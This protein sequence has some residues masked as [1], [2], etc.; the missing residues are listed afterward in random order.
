MEITGTL[1][2]IGETITGTSKKNGNEWSKQQIV[3][4]TNDTYPQD[5]AIDFMGDKISQLTQY[6]V[7][8][9]VVVSINIKGNEYNGKYYNSINGWKI[10]ATV[11]QVGNEDQNPAREEISADAPF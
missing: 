9:P 11:G 2:L 7:G 8:S 10:A 3:V 4:T 6:K 5:I 1:K